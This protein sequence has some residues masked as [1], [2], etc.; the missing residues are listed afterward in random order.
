MGAMRAKA[1]WL[2]AFLGVALGLLLIHR[3]DHAGAAGILD[4][5]ERCP[6]PGSAKCPAQGG[7][8]DRPRHNIAYALRFGH[9]DF[10]WKSGLLYNPGTTG[11]D[12][13][14][15]HWRVAPAFDDWDAWCLEDCKVVR[16]KPGNEDVPCVDPDVVSPKSGPPSEPPG[17]PA[18]VRCFAGD[19][20][21]GI[22]YRKYPKC[23]VHC[24][25]NCNPTGCGSA[26]P[27][28]NGRDGKCYKTSSA[29]QAAT[30]GQGATICTKCP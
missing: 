9:A 7:C 27:W 1:F 25:K 3:N 18:K 12:Y 26:L 30:Q 4:E 2:C 28:K 20:T 19:P 21:G 8:G 17:C 15:W 22:D 5:G 11:P 6:P 24:E 10:D 14:K 23:G 16:E 13:K 29:C